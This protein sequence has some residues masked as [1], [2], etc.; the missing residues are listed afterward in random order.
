MKVVRGL[1]SGACVVAVGGRYACD[2]LW[3]AGDAWQRG[4]EVASVALCAAVVA[5][6]SA[7]DPPRRPWA[8]LTIALALIPVIRVASAFGWGAYGVSLQNLLLIAGNLAF[9]AVMPGFARVLGSS[10]L[11]SERTGDARVKAALTISAI[12]ACGIAFIFY[13]FAELVGH[14]T[15]ATRDAWASVIASGVSTLSDAIVFAGGLYLVWLLRPM[16]G[17]SLARPYLMMALGGAALLVIDVVLVSAGMTA[18]TQLK[19]GTA[20]LIGTFAFACFAAAALVQLALL[21]AGRRG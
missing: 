15:P 17:G 6:F 5:E 21:R 16:V 3:Q 11:L 2:A 13:N 12:A 7:G 20:K 18:Q 10:D 19:D 1:A 4:V 14:G 9:A 8:V